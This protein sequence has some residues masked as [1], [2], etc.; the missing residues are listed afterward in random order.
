MQVRNLLHQQH[1]QERIRNPNLPPPVIPQLQ[2][3]ELEGLAKY[4]GAQMIVRKHLTTFDSISLL[5]EQNLKLLRVVKEVS[6][7]LEEERKRKDAESEKLEAVKE[8]EAQVEALQKELRM[9]QA[10]QG[11]HVKLITIV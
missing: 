4:H 3:E 9:E 1:E 10:R 11:V 8:K 6:A 5:H 7:K 2:Q